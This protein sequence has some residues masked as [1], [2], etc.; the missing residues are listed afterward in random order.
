M[1]SL[2]LVPIFCLSLLSGC[3][4]SPD[5]AFKSIPLGANK[6]LVLS[7]MGNPQRTYRKAGTDRWVY[8]IPGKAG[9]PI[10]KEIWFSEGKVVYKDGDFIRKEKGEAK[11]A[12]FE[13]ID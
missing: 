10:Q 7:E 9:T 8:D 11:D 4:S 13:P 2:F 6:G 12:D 5:A 1:R 3:A